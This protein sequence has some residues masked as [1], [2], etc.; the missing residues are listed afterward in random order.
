MFVDEQGK[1]F[2]VEGT[3]KSISYSSAS[4]INMGEISAKSRDLV[5]KLERSKI[6]AKSI[7]SLT[8]S[9][10]RPYHSNYNL[11]AA[12][13]RSLRLLRQCGCRSYYLHA[14]LKMN[15]KSLGKTI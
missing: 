11:F 15:V 5:L 13:G 10:S 1:A 7:L 9:K 2:T 3:P 8:S 6:K 12:T 4:S 14:H